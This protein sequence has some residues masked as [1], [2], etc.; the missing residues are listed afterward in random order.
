ML[1]VLF[2]PHF[3][4]YCS[5]LAGL[6]CEE[7]VRVASNY[8]ELH[9]NYRCRCQGKYEER[10]TCHRFL[11]STIIHSFIDHEISLSF[12]SNRKIWPA[13]VILLLLMLY[14]THIRIP[15]FWLSTHTQKRTSNFQNFASRSTRPRNLQGVAILQAWFLD[16]LHDDTSIT[17]DFPRKGGPYLPNF[18]T[19]SI[20]S[21]SRDAG[22]WNSL[23]PCA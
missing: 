8:S 21:A 6:G 9:C 10:V 12:S 19:E 2:P 22:M 1:I 17:V 13:R 3:D 16:Q 14:T 5:A 20:L 18:E 15:V 7:N 11:D 23:H 4:P